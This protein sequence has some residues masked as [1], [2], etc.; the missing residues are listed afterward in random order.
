[1]GG[2]DLDIKSEGGEILS[3]DPED[4][5]QTDEMYSPKPIPE[6]PPGLQG[7]QSWSAAPACSRMSLRWHPASE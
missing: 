1:M 6:A 5:F 3:C 2:N 7:R 4:L